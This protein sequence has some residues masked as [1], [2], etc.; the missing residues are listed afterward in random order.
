[1]LALYRSGRQA[2]ALDSYRAT[3]LLL[4]EEL[5]VEPGPQLRKLQR[6]ILD[7]DPALDLP[8]AQAR[9]QSGPEGEPPSA[10]PAAASEPS[11][12]PA[13]GG[14]R[15][16]TGRAVLAAGVA[17]ALAG[18]AAFVPLSRHAATAMTLNANLLALV[19]PGSGAV[20]A[21]VPLRA[22]P[23][24]VA[25]AAGSLWA[26]EPGA[27]LVV[28]VDPA[29]HAVAATIPVGTNPSRLTAGG[30]QVWVLDR[31]DRTASRIDPRT[32]TVAQTISVPS[33]P[34]DVLLSMGSLWATS[35]DAGTVTRIDPGSGRIVSVART[36]GIRAA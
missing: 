34:S 26:A 5:A 30:G 1:M 27:G 35:Q 9:P 29:R 10:G 13:A 14:R 6:A 12:D 31:A 33:R 23:S 18:I 32:D 28:R 21:T 2:D 7:H 16:W 19:S 8:S 20:Q 3:R 22:P 25:A 4:V 17:I 11:R 24:D 36:G 15:Y